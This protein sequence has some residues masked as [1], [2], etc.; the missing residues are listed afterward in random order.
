MLPIGLAGRYINGPKR[1]SRLRTYCLNP[2][3][4]R[5]IFARREWSWCLTM[6][7]N[8]A[9]SIDVQPS[10]VTSSGKTAYCRFGVGLGILA[11]GRGSPAL[12]SPASFW[13]AMSFNFALSLSIE[14]SS[15]ARSVIL[16]VGRRL[17]NFPSEGTNNEFWTLVR[18]D[19]VATSG[20][21]KSQFTPS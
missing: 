13:L 19:N 21:G 18:V 5:L 2:F 9:S 4:E 17:M 15:P 7:S 3:S 12:S 14:R 11:C 1:N 6:S 8:S 16:Y 10:S 20:S